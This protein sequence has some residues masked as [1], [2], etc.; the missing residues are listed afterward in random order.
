MVLF[1]LPVFLMADIKVFLYPNAVHDSSAVK[2]SDIAFVEVQVLKA[3]MC[4]KQSLIESI[5]LIQ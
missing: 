4:V 2:V 1:F 3:I 5:T